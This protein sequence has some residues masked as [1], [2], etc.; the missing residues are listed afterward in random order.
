MQSK[1][2]RLFLEF[3]CSYEM[4]KIDR[5]IVAQLQQSCDS[6]CFNLLDNLTQQNSKLL[7]EIATNKMKVL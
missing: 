2:Y 5:N 1:S 3:L 6:G 7:I 4:I